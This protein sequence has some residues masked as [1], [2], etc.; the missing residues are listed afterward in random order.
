[1]AE[2]LRET[3][4]T[5][6][7]EMPEG[8]PEEMTHESALDLPRF[9]ADL[10][11]ALPSPAPS[12]PL[13][14]W[15]QVRKGQPVEHENFP[16]TGGCRQALICFFH[17]VMSSG[18][19]TDVYI[20][21]MDDGAW[22]REDPEFE[23]LYNRALTVM[24]EA[25]HRISMIHDPESDPDGLLGLLSRNMPFYLSGRLSSY[26]LES[27]AG[28]SSIYAARGCTAVLS[29]C[30]EGGRSPSHTVLYR[31]VNDVALYVRVF[32]THLSR[33][34]PLCLPVPGGA[35]FASQ[36]AGLEEREGDTYALRTSLAPMWLPDARLYGLLLTR[37]PP[38]EIEPRMESFA[39][40]R[41]ALSHGQGRHMEVIPSRLI[42][43]IERSGACTLS[44]S[45]MFCPQD[46]PLGIE[47]TAAILSGLLAALRNGGRF[48]ACLTD[49]VPEGLGVICKPGEAACLY[50]LTGRGALALG[51]DGIL[52][53]LGAWFESITPEQP[54]RAR[55]A[56]ANRIEALV[57]R[58]RDSVFVN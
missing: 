1:V 38:H 21:N 18:K 48:S 26:T 16:G 35:G 5:P 20:M 6:E 29:Y 13:N 12:A 30:A 55:A 57:K 49:E 25:G 58:L 47:D 45:E 11:A 32:E 23:R 53:A 31:N 4:G 8:T 42:D 33:S 19:K 39:R 22:I 3:D 44:A 37:L 17:S 7:D 52:R 28:T 24:E 27:G 46:V 36:L 43:E 40:R 50:G 51:G 9:F 41:A 15:P 2:W 10:C 34:R 56:L 54:D 14:L